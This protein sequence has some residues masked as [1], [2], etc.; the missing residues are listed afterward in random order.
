M[1]R[2]RAQEQPPL[3]IEPLRGGWAYVTWRGIEA[4]IRFEADDK[5]FTLKPIELRVMAPSLDRHREL[6][7]SRIVNAVHADAKVRFALLLHLDAEQH[8]P[9]SMRQMKKAIR[10]G[11]APRHRLERP[12]RR[13]LDD[14]FYASVAQAYADAVAWGMNPR[15]TLAADS[16][17]PADTVARWISTAR[18]KGYLSGATAGKASGAVTEAGE[19]DG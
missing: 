3:V 14:D 18:G 16:D 2:S 6:P 1:S 15:K 10:G 9:F 12:A 13:R 11:L 7:L 4:A 17:T 5:P 8:D 19:R